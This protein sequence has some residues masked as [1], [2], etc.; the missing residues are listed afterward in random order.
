MGFDEQQAIENLEVGYNKKPNKR[1]LSTI[2]EES[3]SELLL[4]GSQDQNSEPSNS[5]I[6]KAS[7]DSQQQD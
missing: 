4:L 5:D 7:A 3:K 6:S 1:N 2:K